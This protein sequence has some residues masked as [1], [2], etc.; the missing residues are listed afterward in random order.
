M[1]PGN[2]SAVRFLPFLPF[3]PIK[4]DTLILSQARLLAFLTCRRRFQLRYL[5]QLS[6]PVAPLVPQQRSAVEQGQKFHQLLERFFLGLPISDLDI[7]DRQLQ[8]W[9]RRFEE[10]LLPLPPGRALPELRLTVPVGRHFLTGRFDLVIIRNEKE[11]PA[12]HIYDWKTSRPRPAEELREEW[13]S[14]LYL[15]MLAESKGA[16]IEGNGTLIPEQ[17]KLTYWYVTDPHTPRTI[18]YSREQH[19]QNWEEIQTVVTDI[20]SCV[21]KGL[22]PLTDNW[23]HC[24]SCTYWAYC[25]RFE[26]GEPEKILAEALARYELTPAPFLEPES[27]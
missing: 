2:A 17:I 13:Q 8:L 7:A 11:Q 22:W 12:V 25:G 21:Q 20:H 14:K 6:W 24:R 16:L 10:N 9:W 18:T 26:G 15:A 27:P 3:L 1:K 4:M 19:E 23:R 5:D